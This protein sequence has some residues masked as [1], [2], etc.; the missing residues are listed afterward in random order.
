MLLLDA[1]LP[2]IVARSLSQAPSAPPKPA[3]AGDTVTVVPPRISCTS[4]ARSAT[5][6]R[7]K[8][9]AP[10]SPAKPSRSRS[11]AS[12]N[13]VADPPVARDPHRQQHRVIA[14]ARQAIRRR[15]EARAVFGG[16]LAV[17]RVRDAGEPRAVQRRRCADRRCR[18][19]TVRCRARAR[20]RRRRG[21]AAAPR[22]RRSPPLSA[23]STASN[24][25]VARQP[26]R[27]PRRSHPARGHRSAAR[28]RCR[29]RPRPRAGTR[30]T[31]ARRRAPVGHQP[32]EA[33]DAAAPWH[34]RRRARST[35]RAH[36]PSDRRRCPRRRRR[37]RS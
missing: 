25:D 22:R 13:G 29:P 20:R 28:R 14:E 23:I 10:S 6:S 33:G 5:P 17:E 9:N 7:P 18:R 34:S 31:R 30:S 36:S 19:S 11:R 16:I 3:G 27:P 26:R 24:G 32:G 37:W 8:R 2:E 1:I 15:A 12:G 35:G 4:S 21:A